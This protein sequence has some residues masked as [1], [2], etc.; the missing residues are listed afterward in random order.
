MTKDDFY[1]LCREALKASRCVSDFSDG[2][3]DKLTR[4]VM[5]V[6]ANRIDMAALEV[7]ADEDAVSARVIGKVRMA[8]AL[9]TPR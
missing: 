4:T 7:R 6:V 5:K 9:E 1:E 2:S 3:I 8:L